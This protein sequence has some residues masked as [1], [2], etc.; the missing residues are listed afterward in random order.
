[1]SLNADT[2]DPTIAEIDPSNQEPLYFHRIASRTRVDIV[3]I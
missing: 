1:M 3:K 2:Q